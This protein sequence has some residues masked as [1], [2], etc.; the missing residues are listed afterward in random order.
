M[1]FNDVF[2][3]FVFGGFQHYLLPPGIFDNSTRVCLVLSLPIAVSKSFSVDEIPISTLR[4]DASDSWFRQKYISFIFVYT[5]LKRNL[6][7][8]AAWGWP[9]FRSS[10]R[11]FD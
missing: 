8:S 5:Y 6:H 7:L 3:S 4:A 11:G 10:D 2:L 1:P 9:M